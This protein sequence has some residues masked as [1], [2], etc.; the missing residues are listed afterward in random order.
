M[1]LQMVDSGQMQRLG[2][3]PAITVPDVV[4]PLGAH[5]PLLAPTSPRGVLALQRSVGNRAVRQLLNPEGAG[6]PQTVQR[7]ALTHVNY[8]GN[9]YSWQAV[10]MRAAN[11]Q[12][13]KNIASIKL[14]GMDMV[15]ASSI[16][17]GPKG[18]TPKHSEQVVWEAVQGECTKGGRKVEWVYTEREPCGRGQ[19]MKNCASF[20]DGLLRKHGAQGDQ[21]P[22]YY[23]FNYPARGEVTLAAKWL[24][25]QHVVDNEDDAYDAAY[26]LWISEHGDTKAMI[27]AAQQQFSMPGPWA[28]GQFK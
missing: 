9:G 28:A 24:F 11:P 10:A 17:P 20:L 13:L 23:S 18:V 5:Q 4:G 14:T 27:A 26:D 7:Y 15:T 3:L 8:T 25:D 12:G 16:P 1:R 6:Q 2:V 21:T 19:G 22:V